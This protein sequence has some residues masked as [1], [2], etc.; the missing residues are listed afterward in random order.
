[1]DMLHPPSLVVMGEKENYKK[2]GYQTKRAK[3]KKYSK[4]GFPE[5]ENNPSWIDGRQHFFEEAKRIT[6]A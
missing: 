3:G 5:K 6:R 1:M 4:E 2:K